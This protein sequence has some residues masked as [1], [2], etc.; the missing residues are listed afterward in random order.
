M[1]RNIRCGIARIDDRFQ[2]VFVFDGIV[3]DDF[4]FTSHQID[5]RFLDPWHSFQCLR[6]MVDTV[7]TNHTGNRNVFFVPE[8][9]SW[10]KRL[11]KNPISH[12]SPLYFIK[13]KIVILIIIIIIRSLKMDFKWDTVYMIPYLWIIFLYHELY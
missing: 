7:L 10:W 5:F 4:G 2:K 6:R 13:I 1:K 9:S 12:I 11:L 8:T 3:D